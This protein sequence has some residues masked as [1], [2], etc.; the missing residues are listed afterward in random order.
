MASIVTSKDIQ[1]ALTEVGVTAGDTV[2]IHSSLKSFGTVEGG[3]QAVIDGVEAV[4]T[5]EGTLVMPTL[6]QVDFTNSYKTSYMDKPS[7]V[8]YLTEY[9]RKLPYVYRSNQETHSVAARG[10]LAYELTFEHKAYGPHICP[11]GE[12]AFSDSSPW[13]K[14]YR[15][16]AKVLFFGVTMRVNTFKHVIEARMVE[17]L[18][19]DVVDDKERFELQKRVLKFGDDYP[20]N[21]IWLFYN[22]TLMQDVLEERGLI[23]KAA[24]GDATIICTEAKTCSDAAYEELMADPEKWFGQEKT[25]AKIDWINDCKAAAKK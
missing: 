16:N 5:K 21:G 22:S 25:T 12:Y 1:N 18:L 3:A 7:D 15:M 17:K 14:M 23:K 8:G 13:M 4:L 11:F 20:A 19:S 10:K 9:F 2:L 24:C 6:S